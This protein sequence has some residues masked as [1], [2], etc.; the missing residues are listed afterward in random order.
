MYWSLFYGLKCCPEDVPCAPE[1][2]V[3][4]AAVEGSILQMSIRP[5]YLPVVFESSIFMLTSI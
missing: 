4:S 3:H 1:K 5:S 2:N